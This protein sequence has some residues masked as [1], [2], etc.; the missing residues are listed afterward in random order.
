MKK[1]IVKSGKNDL[2]LKK[3]RTLVGIKPKN[4]NVNAAAVGIKAEV[5]SHLGGFKL[6][7]LDRGRGSVDKKLDEVRTKKEVAVGT[8]VYHIEGNKR[9]LIP[10][11]EIYIT[12]ESDTN[13]EERQI[14]LDE[15][16]LE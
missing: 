4:K 3:S 13:E 2:V 8:H 6:V 16:A 7:T 9:P 14:V 12:F 11:G 1:L 5:L 15:Y 10:T